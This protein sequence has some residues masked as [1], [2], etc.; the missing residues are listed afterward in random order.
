MKRLLLLAA[1][2]LIPGAEAGTQTPYY[3]GKTINFIVGS[4]AGTA[5]DIYARLL[6]NHI[7]K[8]IPGNP[9]GGHAE[10]AGGGRHRRG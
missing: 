7:G 1:L 3:Q 2:L 10:Y 9:N 8:H 5:Y 4:G 6:A